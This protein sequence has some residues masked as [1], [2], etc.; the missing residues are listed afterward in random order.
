MTRLI[1][2]LFSVFLLATVS[3]GQEPKDY[4]DLVRENEE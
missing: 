2:A 1:L 4:L 3:F